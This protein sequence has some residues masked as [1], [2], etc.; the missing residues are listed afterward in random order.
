MAQEVASLLAS[1]SSELAGVVEH[2]APAVV[3]V[4][5]GTRLTATG[6]IWSADGI[7]VTTSHGVEQDENLSIEL[8]D[9]TP[10]PATMIGR[11]HDTDIALLRAKAQDLPTIEK[12]VPGEVQVGH[13]V[14]ALGRPGAAGLQAT[15]GIIGAR[16][17]S[18]SNDQPEYVLHTDAV[19]YPGFS[20]GPLVN[21]S[22]QMVG[23]NNLMFGRGRGVA[24]GVPTVEHV[25]QSLLAHG[26]VQQGYLGI[27]M[28]LVA[29]PSNL[30]QALSLAQE[31]GLL[32]VQV[33]PNSPAEQAGLFLGDTLL[34]LNNRA[35]EDVDQ[36]RHE[37][38][39]LGAGQTIN[40][41]V[42]RGGKLRAIN[43][44]LTAAR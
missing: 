25:A 36:L 27:R 16:L 29:L 32:V 40:V 19:L 42:L 6:I 12:A 44:T 22:G 10:H 7:V 34:S 17:E 33:E 43:V 15:I 28:Q 18:Q 4:D 24:L 9:G 2:V 39:H 20:G 23:L 5:D 21:V 26:R 13:L 37:L 1:L 3:R 30:R 35:I 41:G 38:R 8:A 31:R 11:D 14:L